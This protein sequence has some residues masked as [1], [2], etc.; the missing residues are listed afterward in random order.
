MR[1]IESTNFNISETGATILNAAVKGTIV[2]KRNPIGY[3]YLLESAQTRS[4]NFVKWNL[5]SLCLCNALWG[6]I[7]W[8]AN[9]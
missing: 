6:P 9:F 8:I 4:S 5:N 3:I 1:T 2:A 7:G